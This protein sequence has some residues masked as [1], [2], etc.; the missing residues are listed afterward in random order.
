[1]ATAF[2][3]VAVSTA[4]TVAAPPASA[5]YCGQV[6]GSTPKSVLTMS[7]ATVTGVRAGR[8]ACFDRL[9]VDLRGPVA[10]YSVAYVPQ[11]RADGSGHVVPVRGGARLQVVVT[12]PSYDADY[13]LTYRP[14]NRRELVRV[15][16]F[17]T[18]RQVA[19]AGSF[20]GYT[21]FGLGV[22]ARLPFRVFILPGP[23]DGSRLVIDV[24]HRW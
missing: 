6:W 10:G 8:H 3:A 19:W 23:G 20:E 11:V 5:A 16:G 17:R 7:S 2:A 15:S 21:S 14:T 9:V 1:M 4:L 24:G 22:R 12:A 13:N 18:F